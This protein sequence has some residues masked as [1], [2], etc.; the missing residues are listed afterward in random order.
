MS[1][2]NL[3]LSPEICDVITQL[4]YT[5]PTP[6]QSQAIPQVLCGRDIFGCAQTGT[7]K[8]A[9]FLLP[10]IEVLHHVSVG[11]SR[12]PRAIILEPT[13]E[14][15]AQVFDNIAKFSSATNLRAALLVGGEL[16]SDQEKQLK[17]GADIIVATP[18]R[19][20]DLFDRGRVLMAGIEMFVIDEADRMLDM[21][22]IP[23]IERIVSLLPT[24]RQNLFFSATVPDEIRQLSQQWLDNPREIVV[25]P[26]TK[27]ANT[28]KHYICQLSDA[29]KS[30]A[31]C[32]ILDSTQPT[33]AI[34]F[35]NRKR[36]VS[37]LATSLKKNG[38]Q[39]QGL[40]GDMPQK[41]RNETLDDF[42][43]NRCRL[44]VASDVAARGLDVTGLSLVVNFD[45]PN[46]ADEY[47][48][49]IGRTGRAGQEGLA[50]TFVTK[51][52]AK[53]IKAI[54][55]MLGEEIP[56]Y[57]LPVQEKAPEIVWPNGPVVGFGPATPAFMNIKF[58]VKAA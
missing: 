9:S 13:R 24:K 31:L 28:V 49:R 54:Y 1:F 37:S 56:T 42:R 45:V 38:Y 12:L 34:V 23:D 8:T 11:K 2:E 58:N 3:G 17:K 19:L 14:L 35:C 39:A 36:I 47:V 40:H 30:D 55:K 5:S 16:M 32:R 10:L 48:H 15:A 41:K 26:S 29:Q 33:S 44:L 53:L 22:F 7:G 52:D 4:G 57:E 21:G 27:V 51:T 43:Q 50:V 20:L 18:G 6:I 25:T 46:N